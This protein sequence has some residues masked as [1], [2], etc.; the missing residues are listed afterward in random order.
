MRLTRRRLLR[1]GL[2][3]GATVAAGVGGLFALRGGAPAITGLKVLGAQ[4]YRTFSALAA[5]AFPEGLVPRTPL[6][7]ARAFDGF[8]ADEP[9][10]AQS[11]TKSA[12]FLLEFGPVIFE[13]RLITFS[14]LEPL[15]RVA[16]FHRWGSS[17]SEL[18]RQV[19]VGFKKFLSLVF[20]DQPEV[21][22]MFS[23][24]GPL[25]REATP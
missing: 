2:G 19:F 13:R 24:E 10:W 4:E 15:E 25:I 16:H 12:L 17:D 7:L 11:E 3:A 22:P 1:F 20:Y 23:Y 14:H 18:R 21:W 8:L 6:D 5:A 9:D